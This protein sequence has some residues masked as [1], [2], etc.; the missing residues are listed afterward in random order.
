VLRQAVDTSCRINVSIRSVYRPITGLSNPE[1][2]KALAFW[3]SRPSDGIIVGRDL[4][5]RAIAGLLNRIIVHEPINDNSDLKVRVA[6]V[7][8]RRRFGSDITGMTLSQLFPT[9]DFPERLASVLAAI[10]LDAPQYADCVLS[11]GSM[12]LLHTELVILP[13]FAPGHV[14]KWAAT[15][16]FYFDRV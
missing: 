14:T 1:A 6:G 13:V 4:P 10:N 8:I 3:E 11:N 5:S 7:A 12:E 15:F 2:G 16:C 9:P